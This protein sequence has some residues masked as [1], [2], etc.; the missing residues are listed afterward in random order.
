MRLREASGEKLFVKLE[1]ELLIGFYSVRKLL[2]T[3]KVSDSTK[4]QKYEVNWFANIQ[5]VDYLNWHHIDRL[6]DLNKTNQETRNIRFICDRFIHSYVLI[7]DF[8]EEKSNGVYIASDSDRRKKLYH[9][10]ADN[11]VAIFR[12]VGRDYPSHSKG[13]R[14]PDTGEMEAYEVS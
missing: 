5:P 12:L 7:P 3:V 9:I 8:K 13:I 10:S 6:F 2:D 14:N 4:E 1:K 11:I